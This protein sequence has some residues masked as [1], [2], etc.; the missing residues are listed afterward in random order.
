MIIVAR[1]FAEEAIAKQRQI[2]ASWGVMADWKEKGCY[3]TNNVSYVTNQ[4]QQFFKL[5]EKNLVYRDFKP[6]YWS[7]SSRYSMSFFFELS[8]FINN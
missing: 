4:F 5:Y 7:P 3:F 8:I 1:K 2:F 6:V